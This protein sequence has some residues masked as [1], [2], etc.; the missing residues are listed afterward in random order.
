MKEPG[1]IRIK[2]GSSYIH[3]SMSVRNLGSILDNTLRTE[4]HVYSICKSFYY[5][6]RNIGLIRKILVKPLIS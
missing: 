5:Q 2:V 1:N 4:K 6:I 3:S